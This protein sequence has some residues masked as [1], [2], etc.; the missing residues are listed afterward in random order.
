MEIES[1][2]EG[3]RK[4]TPNAWLC[5]VKVEERPDWLDRDGDL[6]QA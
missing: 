5:K 3:Y 6:L 1:R 2:S 4:S